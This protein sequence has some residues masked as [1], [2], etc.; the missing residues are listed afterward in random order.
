MQGSA[1]PLLAAAIGQ[2]RAMIAR[3]VATADELIAN[4]QGLYRSIY[5]TNF[6]ALDPTEVKLIAVPATDQ[7]FDLSLAVRDRIPEW[8]A[9]GLMRDGAATAVRNAMR[10]LREVLG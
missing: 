3:P 1:T 2:W 10:V 5:D 8:R 6:A 7:L 4:M 9:Q